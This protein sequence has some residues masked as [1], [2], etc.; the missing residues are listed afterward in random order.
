MKG[1]FLGV[2]RENFNK[3]RSEKWT[4][5]SNILTA[6]CL[7]KILYILIEIFP[8]FAKKLIFCLS[9][10]NAESSVIETENRCQRI[11]TTNKI[12]FTVNFTP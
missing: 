12:S 2:V 1:S 9:F 10:A 11:N 4:W 3:F 7:N 6:G 8:M 5:K